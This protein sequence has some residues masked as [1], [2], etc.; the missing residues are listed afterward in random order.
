MK[1]STSVVWLPRVR[2]VKDF[3]KGCLYRAFEFGIVGNASNSIR[4]SLRLLLYRAFE[5]GIV[6]N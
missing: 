6:G 1:K 2:S 3:P 4:E 5:F